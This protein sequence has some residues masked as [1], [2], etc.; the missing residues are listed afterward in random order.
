MIALYRSGRQTDALRAFE[1]TRDRLRDDLGLD[2]S[3]PLRRLQQQILDQAP[4]LDIDPPDPGEQVVLLATDIAGST[5][6]WEADPDAMAIAL[7]RHDELVADAITAHDGD[8]FKHTGDGV[9]AV[10]GDV[11]AALAAAVQIQS[12][13]ANEPWRTESPL[14][15]RIGVDRGAVVARAGDYFGR[16]VNRVSR[17]MSSG[18]GGQIVAHESLAGA[19]PSGVRSLGGVDLKGVGRVGL[20]QVDVDGHVNEFPELRTDRASGTLDRDGFDRAVRGFE[21][22]EQLGEGAHS[23]VYRAYQASVGREVAVKVIRPEHA[24]QPGFVKRFEC[25]NCRK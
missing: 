16:V 21:L 18:H 24:N 13:L 15:V 11:A 10:F 7:A 4:E 17:I 1:R 2:P 8:T 23:I 3:P 12:D 9:L 14:R 20:V 5:E 6:L 25:R 19:A 22:R